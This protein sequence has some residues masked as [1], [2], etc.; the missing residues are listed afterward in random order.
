MLCL[1]TCRLWL[2]VPEVTAVVAQ[3]AETYGVLQVYGRRSSQSEGLWRASRQQCALNPAPP[4]ISTGICLCSLS[5]QEPTKPVECISVKVVLRTWGVDRQVWLQFASMRQTPLLMR[6]A[7]MTSTLTLRIS[8]VGCPL[9]C[10]SLVWL[11]F[12]S[13]LP[14]RSMLL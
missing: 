11:G 7:P 6:M 3:R 13:S 9:H 2:H 4:F 14:K 12:A 10:F 1:S 5:A 8:Q